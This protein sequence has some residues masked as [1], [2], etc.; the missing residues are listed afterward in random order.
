MESQPLDHPSAPRGSLTQF[1]F[2]RRQ[3]SLIKINSHVLNDKLSFN[4]L[5]LAWAVITECHRLSGFTKTRHLLF[6]ILE[7]ANSK[8]KIRA[9]AVP[10]ESC[11]PGPLLTM[12]YHGKGGRGRQ[13]CLVSLLK[14]TLIPSRGPTLMT[15]S[16]PNHLQGLRLQVPLGLGLPCE[17]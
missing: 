6:T 4:P 5:V 15:S 11:I 2:M 8:I 10:G 3:H 14:R 13:L 7:A 1:I 9:D 17:F 16:N 12:S